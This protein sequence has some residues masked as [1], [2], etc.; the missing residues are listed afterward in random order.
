MRVMNDIN[1]ADARSGLS[2][3]F[4]GQTGKHGHLEKKLSAFH[5]D[6]APIFLKSYRQD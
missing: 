1:L 6:P 2:G 3:G 5:F 4:R